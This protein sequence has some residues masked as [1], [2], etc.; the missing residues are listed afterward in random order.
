VLHRNAQEAVLAQTDILALAQGS[1]GNAIAALEQLNAIPEELRHQVTQFPKTPLQAL[2]LAKMIDK[3]LDT[4]TQLWLVDYLQYYYWQ[5]LHQRLILEAFE[6]V[7]QG[8]LCYVQPRLVWESALLQLM[9]V[10]V[11]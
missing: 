6:K 1:P 3:S 11:K 10:K 4:Q 8:L 5:R 7:R 9:K 2:E